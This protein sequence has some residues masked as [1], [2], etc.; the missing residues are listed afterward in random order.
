[1][2]TFFSRCD[3]VKFRVDLPVLLAGMCRVGVGVKA[4]AVS[5]F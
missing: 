3:A 5:V 4:K 1:M 2:K